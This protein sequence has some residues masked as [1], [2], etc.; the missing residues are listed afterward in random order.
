MSKETEIAAAA[1]LEQ[2]LE[3]EKSRHG[4]IQ[5]LGPTR[6]RY[7][8]VLDDLDHLVQVT[9]PN[10][11]TQERICLANLLLCC[12]NVGVDRAMEMLQG[13]KEVYDART[14]QEVGRRTREVL[15]S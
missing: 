9:I 13:I 3:V 5:A 7:A 10:D 14:A 15:P 11:I 1:S 2:E 12:Y 6:G 8:V 4:I